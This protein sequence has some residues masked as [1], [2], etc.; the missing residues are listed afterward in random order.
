MGIIQR[1]EREKA[2][3]RKAILN[4][5]KELILEQGVERFSME[6]LARKMELSKA[7]VYLYFSG[8][9]A[10]LYALGEESALL[11]LEQ[12]KPVLE[13]GLSGLA[14]LKYFWIRYVEMFGNSNDMFIIFKVRTYLNSWLLTGST[15]KRLLSP[16]VDA[17]IMAVKTT[18]EQCKAEGIFDP[19]LDSAIAVRLLLSA[20]S[21]VLGDAAGIPSEEKMYRA[22]LKKMLHVFQIMLWGFAKEGVN[23]AYLDIE[24][25]LNPASV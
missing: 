9:E 5:A 23:R 12:F 2:E 15:E 16:H 17:I 20:F 19:D 6:E 3:R 8:K 14:T 1:R 13:G 24:S 18:I 11:F 4:C 7:T 10:L 21:I 25:W 22:T